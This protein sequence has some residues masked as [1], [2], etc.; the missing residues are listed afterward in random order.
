MERMY[1][2][3]INPALRRNTEHLAPNSPARYLNFPDSKEEIR[4]LQKRVVFGS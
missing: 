1:T 4:P 3:S 2:R